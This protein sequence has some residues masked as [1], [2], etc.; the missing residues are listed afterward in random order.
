MVL[1]FPT[2]S[3]I[4]DNVVVRSRL[5][6]IYIFYYVRLVCLCITLRVNPVYKE[7][8]ITVDVL[9][10]RQNDMRNSIFAVV[11][12]Y[13][14]ASTAPERETHIHTRYTV[15]DVTRGYRLMSNI[16]IV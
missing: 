9:T 12:Y 14:I 11:F 1:R 13:S 5:L 3:V 15:R 7:R 2:D 6:T 16:T 10:S 4:H 8:C